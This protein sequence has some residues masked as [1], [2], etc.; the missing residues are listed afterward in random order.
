MP[1]KDPIKARESA[2]LRQKKYQE[3]KKLDPE[4]RKKMVE[5]SL[6]YQQEHSEEYRKRQKEWREKNQ[7]KIKEYRDD[8]YAQNR[9]EIIEKVVEWQKNNNGAHNEKV[10]KYRNTE[11]GKETRKIDRNSRRKREMEAMTPWVNKA[12]LKT[13][14]AYASRLNRINAMKGPVPKEKKKVVDHL[15]PLRHPLVCGLHVPDNLKVVNAGDNLRKSNYFDPKDW[16]DYHLKYP[17][18]SATL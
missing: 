6:K 9:D 12:H 3:K 17:F 5:R 7:K 15:I 16:E 10:Y 4:F 13:E 8:Y 2:R 1:Y 14:Y 18:R 11:K